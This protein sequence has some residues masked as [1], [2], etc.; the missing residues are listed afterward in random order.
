MST[1]GHI[2]S[3]LTLCVIV[4]IVELTIML[5]FKRTYNVGFFAGV[6]V[7]NLYEMAKEFF[8]RNVR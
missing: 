1:K 5:F 2:L 3:F 8:R 7:A 4:G 6:A